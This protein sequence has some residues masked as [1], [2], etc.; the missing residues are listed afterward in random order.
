MVERMTEVEERMLEMRKACEH[1]AIPLPADSVDAMIC[2]FECT[3]CS[4]CSTNIFKG[5]CPNC[6]GELVRRPTRQP[7]EACA[8]ELIYEREDSNLP[9]TRCSS[10]KVESDSSGWRGKR[11]KSH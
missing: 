11:P 6:E 10:K 1:C 7:R 5:I 3:F 8:V 4:R 9:P 2:S